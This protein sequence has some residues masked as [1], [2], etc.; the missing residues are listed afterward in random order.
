MTLSNAP[1]SAFSK[2]AQGSSCPLRGQILDIDG[3]LRTFD[4]TLAADGSELLVACRS[5]PPLPALRRLRT[6]PPGS[7]GNKARLSVTNFGAGLTAPSPR[8]FLVIHG[9]GPLG[10]S[11][12]ESISS[13]AFAS[14]NETL[15]L[16]SRSRR[17][18]PMCRP[19]RPS[20]LLEIVAL[21]RRARNVRI[22]HSV[23]RSL[24]IRGI[25]SLAS[26]PPYRKRTLRTR[27]GNSNG[28]PSRTTMNGSATPPRLTARQ[29]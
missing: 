11:A 22:I 18:R 15:D 25:A 10:R 6:S 1:N 27:V 29:P 26:D 21:I 12:G 20:K 3:S 8:R 7:A 14:Q 19:R 16:K 17:T 5:S 9:E 4:W 13:A 28:V 23:L 2:L 24:A